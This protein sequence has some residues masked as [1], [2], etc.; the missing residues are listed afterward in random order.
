MG[1]T[2]T[3]ARVI[4]PSWWQRLATRLKPVSTRRPAWH[5]PRPVTTRPRGTRPG[6]HRADTS[7]VLV[8]HQFPDGREL[9][10]RRRP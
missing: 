9:R 3:G 8:A 2:L 6:R 1:D 4:R 7:G 5:A 10:V